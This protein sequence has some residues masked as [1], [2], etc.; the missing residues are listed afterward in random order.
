M[1]NILIRHKVKDYDKWKPVFDEHQ[2]FRKAG[3]EKEARLFRNID[4][5]NEITIL[6]K[7]DTIEKA[8]KFTE[9]SDLK[10]AMQKAGVAGKP[11]IYFIEEIC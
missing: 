2:A 6:Q 11:D 10:K 7:W 9:S 5:P 8:R 3:G 1:V 4:D